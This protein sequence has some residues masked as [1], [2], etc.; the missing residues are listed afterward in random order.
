[1]VSAARR[2]ARATTSGV[3][4]ATRR[5]FR[6]MC[7]ARIRC[8]ST[9]APAFATTA[10]RCRPTQL[11]Q[12]NCLLTHL[13]WDHVQ[14]LPFFTPLLREGSE[15]RCLRAGARR[16]SLAR[17]G[18]VE[19]DPPAAVPGQCRRVARHG[20]LSRHRR[21]RLLDRRVQ[22]EGPPDPAPRSDARLPGRVQ[23]SLGRLPV[24]I[25]SSRSMA[26]TR[27]RRARSNWSK[28]STC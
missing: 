28:A 26:A 8:C 3:T 27:R 17:R 13:H 10:S 2:R 5:A 22:R 7:R 12:G 23:R 15:P 11:F 20:Q 14:G 6:S 24:A 19:H 1:M 16:R 4:A 9:W 25:T 21:Q 18:G